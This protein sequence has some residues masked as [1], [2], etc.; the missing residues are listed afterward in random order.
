MAMLTP[1]AP[2][3]FAAATAGSA[4]SKVMSGIESSRAAAFEEQQL[5]IKSDLARTAAAQ[6]EARRRD[7]LT[8]ALETIS[9]VWAGRGVS[10]DSPTL[11]AVAGNEAGREERNIRAERLNYLTQADL[12]RQGAEFQGRRRRMSLLAGDIGALTTLA[13]G[14]FNY[15]DYTRRQR[16]SP[17]A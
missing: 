9:A 17:L 1:I 7:D 16:T 8:S 10:M 3:I 15:A 14:A 2:Y 11:R 6:S 12:Y 5:K 13:G 4:A